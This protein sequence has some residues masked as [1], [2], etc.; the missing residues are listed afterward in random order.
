MSPSFRSVRLRCFQEFEQCAFADANA[1]LKVKCSKTA[2]DVDIEAK[3]KSRLLSKEPH[4]RCNAK[5]SALLNAGGLYV[6]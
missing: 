6:P 5:L 4:R 3:G 1:P 2:A